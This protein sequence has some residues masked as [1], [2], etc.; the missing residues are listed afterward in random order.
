MASPAVIDIPGPA[1]AAGHSDHTGLFRQAF[2]RLACGVTVVTT[3]S[4]DGPRGL[5]ATAVCSVSLEPLLV[6]ACIHNGSRTLAALEQADA[7]AV[8]ILRADQAG[9]AAAFATPMPDQARFAAAP[10]RLHYGV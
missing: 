1:A 8:N 9:V 2:A 10:Y 4:P 3:M 5:T 7:F 6:L